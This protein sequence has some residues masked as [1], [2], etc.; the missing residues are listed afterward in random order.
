MDDKKIMFL[1][2]YVV[3]VNLKK[4]GVSDIQFKVND[5][6]KEFEKEYGYNEI[7]TLDI[8]EYLYNEDYILDYECIE[9]KDTSCIIETNY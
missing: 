5:Y 3:I 6:T 9:Y 7:S 2:D 8:I 4:V 1:D